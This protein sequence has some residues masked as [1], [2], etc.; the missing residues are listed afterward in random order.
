MENEEFFELISAGK[1]IKAALPGAAVI[2]I[3]TFILLPAFNYAKWLTG[4]SGPF[5]TFPT[6]FDFQFYCAFVILA[7]ILEFGAYLNLYQKMRRKPFL[8]I[9]EEGIYLNEEMLPFPGFINGS[10]KI[11]LEWSNIQSVKRNLNGLIISYHEK[12]KKRSKKVDLR[13]VGEKEKL[14]K[15]LKDRC[16]DNDIEWILLSGHWED[17]L[18]RDGI[19]DV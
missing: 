5:V 4:G 13:W 15:I 7:L 19:E 12:G 2:V 16:Q 11:E 18:G 17:D 14:I 8:T 10:G 6:P 9:K 3:A 1:F